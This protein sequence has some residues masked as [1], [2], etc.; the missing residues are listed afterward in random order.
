M[1][2]V[3]RRGPRGH[4]GHGVT[5]DRF[6]SPTEVNEK[7]G[8]KISWSCSVHIVSL[9]TIEFKDGPGKM[10]NSLLPECNLRE[11]VFGSVPDAM[12]GAQIS[13]IRDAPS[14]FRWDQSGYYIKRDSRSDPFY[15]L[16]LQ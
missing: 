2:P 6:P 16:E 15:L 1:D 8:S 12:N 13:N 11:S 4:V 7:N 9:S 3:Y 5:R 14:K 10:K